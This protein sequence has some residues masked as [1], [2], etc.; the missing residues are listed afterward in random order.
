M[1]KI[2]LLL[3]VIAVLVPFGMVGYQSFKTGFSAKEEPSA[4][5]V[6]M[7]RQIR[8]LAIPLSQ[9]NAPN[10]VPSSADVLKEAR[11]HFADHCASCHGNDGKGKTTI[12]QGMYPKVPDLT[13]PD[14][15]SMTDGELF[16]IIHN[17]IRFT[18]MPAWGKGPPEKDMDSWQLVH[19]IRHLPKLTPVELE[20][21]KQYNPISAME[22]EEEE[23]IEKFLSGEDTPESSPP[24]HAH[25]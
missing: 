3:V 13:K 1:W 8:L 12:G 14:T 11:M 20:D 21:M 5:E 25:H 23:E 18:G 6:A 19:F 9:R 7:A 24:E 15:Q 22:R 17:G 10:P 2:V 16:F 4:L